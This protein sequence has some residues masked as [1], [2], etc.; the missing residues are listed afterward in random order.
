M[1]AQGL[2]RGSEERRIAM[3][4]YDI[5]LE[6]RDT[7]HYRVAAESLEEARVAAREV[8]IDELAVSEN[9]KVEGMQSI[10]QKSAVDFSTKGWLTAPCCPEGGTP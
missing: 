8:F 3:P 7:E 2:H 5:T 9:L 4:V 1:L 10:D 6:I